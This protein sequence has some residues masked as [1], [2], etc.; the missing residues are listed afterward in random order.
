M[1]ERDRE[2]DR[3]TEWESP[4]FSPQPYNRVI[5]TDCMGIYL[6]MSW[7][8]QYT[9]LAAQIK[10][11]FRT[12]MGG[13][14]GVFT[15]LLRFGKPIFCTNEKNWL[16]MWPLNSMKLAYLLVKIK[17]ADINWNLLPLYEYICV[18]EGPGEERWKHYFPMSC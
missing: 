3:E 7:I 2:R 4:S 6:G 16:Q 9:A 13:D 8:Q 11:P 5:L 10:S 17:L 15:P 1:R 18:S 12:T 14:K